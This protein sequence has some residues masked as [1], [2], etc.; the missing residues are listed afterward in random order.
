MTETNLE[1]EKLTDGDRKYMVQTLATV[2]M[3]YDQSPSLSTCLVV[4]KSVVNKFQFLKDTEGT[5]EVSIT[6]CLLL[7]GM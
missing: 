4:A 2:L 5:S 1:E 3:T 6:I 7:I